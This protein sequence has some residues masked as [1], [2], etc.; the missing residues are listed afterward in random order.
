MQLKR[1]IAH[2]AFNKH[3]DTSGAYEDFL[4][5]WEASPAAPRCNVQCVHD[6]TYNAQRTTYT[7]LHTCH[8]A[9]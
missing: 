7:V 3:G 1:H 4:A 9:G 5:A 6:A 8:S 2:V